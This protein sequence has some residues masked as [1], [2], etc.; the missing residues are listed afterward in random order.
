MAFKTTCRRRQGN[1]RVGQMNK[2]EQ[3]Y[4]SQLEALRLCGDIQFWLYE[5]CKLRIAVATFY[6]PDFIIIDNDGQVILDDVKGFAEDD[7][8]VK[9]KVA[10]SKYPYFLFRLVTFNNNRWSIKDIPADAG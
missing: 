6:T 7:A 10:A 2:L 8:V 3:R 4:S 9:I 1:T 5:S